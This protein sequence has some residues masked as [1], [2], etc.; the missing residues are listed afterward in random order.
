MVSK[1]D[2]GNECGLCFEPTKYELSIERGDVIES[3]TE[4]EQSD[5]KFIHQPGITKTF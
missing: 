1:L 2:K 4:T 3:Y 5:E